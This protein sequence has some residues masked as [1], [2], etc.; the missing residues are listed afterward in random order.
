[1]AKGDSID[2]EAE[3]LLE[4]LEGEQRKARLALLEDLAADGVELDELREATAAGRLALLPVERS[5]AGEGPCYTAEEVAEQA[6]VDLATL[7]RYLRA[8][9]LPLPEP[10]EPVLSG[11]DLESAKRVKAFEEVGLPEEG[12]L[13]VARTIGMATARIAQAN[14]ELIRKV[15]V[16][17][18]DSEHDLALRFAAAA[19][20]MIPLVGPTL[21]YS[22]QKHLLEQI[23]RDVIE[24]ADIAAGTVGGDTVAAVCFADLVDFTKLGERVDAEQLGLVAGRLE[25]IATAV[26]T[27]P[28]RVVK[29]IGDAAMLVSVEPEP[30]IDAA[31]QLVDAVDQEGEEFP[32]LRAG[33]GYGPVL[34]QGGDYYGRPVNLASRITG[35]ARPGS[36][37]ADEAAREAVGDPYH[38]SFAGERRLKGIDGR[39]KLFRVRREPKGDES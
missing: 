14:R 23:R 6:G 33:I 29:L 18:D 7:Q 12:M 27:S 11:I 16:H 26:A 1:M 28:V 22:M 31:L 8:L 2:F 37:L 10:G 32:Q 36:V 5:L 21:A 17:E 13:Q 15:L 38:Y 39:V 30:L 35:V 3:G 4:G 24:T 20:V 34:G 9:G 25:E 19:R